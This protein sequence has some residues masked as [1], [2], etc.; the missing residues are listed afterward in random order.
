[1]VEVLLKIFFKVQPIKKVETSSLCFMFKIAGR[2]AAGASSLHILTGGQK[3]LSE[4]PISTELGE[5]GR[6][7]GKLL[8]TGREGRY[9]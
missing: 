9:R 3:G 2:S 5:E 6:L 1:M 7:K 8:P 4:G